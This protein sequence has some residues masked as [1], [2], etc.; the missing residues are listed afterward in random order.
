MCSCWRAEG[1]MRMVYNGYHIAQPYLR[2]HSDKQ[3]AQTAV[4][5]Y[6][7]PWMISLCVFLQDI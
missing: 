7:D 6:L 5:H 2:P 4:I 3:D 1:I